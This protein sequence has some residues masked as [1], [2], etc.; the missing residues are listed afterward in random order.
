MS[1]IFILVVKLDRDTIETN[2]L[3]QIYSIPVV[4]VWLS[5]F[6]QF[7]HKPGGR[8]FE[9]LSKTTWKAEAATK[10]I[11]CEACYAGQA[12]CYPSKKMVLKS[13]GNRHFFE[14]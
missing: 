2:A 12:D 13:V 11:S 1:N 6:P 8:E 3:W 14:V 10:L 7:E 4:L 9:T 5:R